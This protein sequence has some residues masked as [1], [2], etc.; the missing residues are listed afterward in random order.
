[1][2]TSLPQF[3]LRVSRA[4]LRLS[5][6]ALVQTGGE[7]RAFQRPGGSGLL[8]ALLCIG[9]RPGRAGMGCVARRVDPGSLVQRSQGL[10]ALRAAEALRKMARWQWWGVDRQP[11][12]GGAV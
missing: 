4:Q 2:V 5:F 9:N 10:A 11:L 6:W 12:P 7:P 1:M 3:P 8:P